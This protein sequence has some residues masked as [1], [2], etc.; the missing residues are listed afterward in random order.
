MNAP[1]RKLKVMKSILIIVVIFAL[2]SCASNPASENNELLTSFAWTIEKGS[3]DGEMPKSSET[4][5]FLTDGTYR[6]QSGEVKVNGKWRWTK[7]DE[8]YL[9]T[10]GMIMDGQVNSFDL[11]TESYIR[12]VELTDRN[13]RTLERGKGDTWDSGFAKE[14]NYTSQSL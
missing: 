7:E 2:G 1:T 10:D 13:L 8:I 11:A 4:Y 9:Q 5:M 6:F 14:R 3:I 12:V